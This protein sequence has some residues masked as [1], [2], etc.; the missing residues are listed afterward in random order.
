MKIQFSPAQQKIV[1]VLRDF[2]WHCVFGE[3]VMKDDR[4]RISEIRP[5]LQE[6]GYDIESQ[7]CNLHDHKSRI[8]MRRI[9]K[10]PI[11]V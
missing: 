3:L 10:L 1:D 5:K 7:S 8:F 9:K 11:L 2:E 6:K 4:K